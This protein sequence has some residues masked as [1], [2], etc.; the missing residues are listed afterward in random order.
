[1]DIYIARVRNMDPK[2][3]GIV[4]AENETVAKV[5]IARWCNREIGS[6]VLNI[7]T[8]DCANS[9]IDSLVP[10]PHPDAEVLYCD[11]ELR[12]APGQDLGI[13]DILNMRAEIQNQTALRNDAET[14]LTI[15]T[16]RVTLLMGEVENCEHGLRY[17]SSIND[18]LKSDMRAIRAALLLPVESEIGQV[19]D[20]INDMRRE[21]DLIRDALRTALNLKPDA[22]LEDVQA[23]LDGLTRAMVDRDTIANALNLSRD[24]STNQITDSIKTLCQNADKLHGILFCLNLKEDATQEEAQRRIRHLVNQVN[25]REMDLRSIAE[26]LGLGI[27]STVDA[28]RKRI[29]DARGQFRTV[30]Q[31]KAAINAEDDALNRLALLLRLPQPATLGQVL[32]LVKSLIERLVTILDIAPPAIPS[33]DV[34]LG[35]IQMLKNKDLAYRFPHG[36]HQHR[37]RH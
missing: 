11:S 18:W 22:K 10:S 5:L 1:M 3:F 13:A 7:S 25:D 33:I 32:H 35:H 16:E 27:T 12:R 26:E 29:R 36:A 28:M 2:F 17:E 34:I 15:L 23:K 21:H 24:A 30:S 20:K 6:W 19:L 31:A 8:Q 37:P 4:R 9:L 14:K